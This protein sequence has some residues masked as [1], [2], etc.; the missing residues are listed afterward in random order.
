MAQQSP[1]I[2]IPKK[3][4]DE[5]DWTTPIRNL[6]AQSYG[7]SPENY[8]AEC[9]ALQRCRQDAVRGAGSEMTAR[10]LLYKYFGQLELLELRFAEIRVTFPW[11]DAFTSKLTTQT[12]LAYEKASI[13][14]QI[15][16]THSA[17]ASTQNRSDPEGLKRSFYYF[18]TAAG[19]L[20]YINENFLHAPSTDLSRDV[21]KFLVDTMIAQAHE[22]FFEKCRDEKKA[23]GLIAK[24][25]AQT[26]SL[27]SAL[28]E[29]VKEFQGK[30]I[31][32]HNWVM[33]IGIKAKYFLS[34]SHYYRSL[35]DNAAGKHGDALARLIVAE[36]AAK[37]AHTQ[38]STS[39]APYFVT[40]QSPTLPSD[41]G[42]AILDLTKT[43]LAL[44]TEKK[45][46]AQRDNDL[47]YNAV[48]PAEGTLS[49]IDKTTVA[50]PIPI[51]EV[52]GA[53]DVQKTIGPD[54][55]VKLI[56]LSVHESAS[57]YS[58]EKAKLVRG[59]VEKSDTADNEYRAA[60][61][62][63]GVREGLGRYRAM[64]EGIVAGGDVVPREVRSWQEEIRNT[65]GKE[66][67]DGLLRQL[68]RLKTN[69]RSELD[70]IG[71]D[72]EIESKDC[73][74]GRL[75]Y[76]HNWTQ[77]PSSGLTKEFRQE[78]K[79]HLSALDAASAS[80]RQ[81]TGMWESVRTDVAILLE[82]DKL[83]DVFT[84]QAQHGHERS[85]SLL[86]I[87]DEGEGDWQEREKIGG[88]VAEIEERIGRLNK[89][90]RERKETL[91]D[92][93]EKIQTDDVSHLLLLNRR[94]SS[95][96]PTLFA[97]ELEKFKPYQTRIQS[98][99][100]YQQAALQEISQYWK[101]LR[102]LAGRGAGAR[103]WEEKEKRKTSSIKQFGRARDTWMEIREGIAKGIQFYSDLLELT[104]HLRRS[105]KSFVSSRSAERQGLISK[106]E[107]ERRLT[108]SVSSPPP[109][110][111]P[112]PSMENT[113]S[114]MSLRGPSSPPPL[115]TWNRP[116][117]PPPPQQMYHSPSPPSHSPYPSQPQRSTYDQ[118]PSA[119]PH[120]P[121][122][123]G[124]LS[125]ASGISSQFSMQ[126]SN[127][128]TPSQP[129]RPPPP[130]QQSFPPLP[131]PQHQPQY[132]SSP[133]PPPP[134]ARQS[135]YPPPPSLPSQPYSNYPQSHQQ[136]SSSTSAF[137]PPPPPLPYQQYA[138]PQNNPSQHPNPASPPQ[139][140]YGQP[141][142][143]GQ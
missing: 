105:V 32:D 6:I 83:E 130:P 122:P 4:T 103:K 63:L 135:S 62:S 104:A 100:Q 26:A 120:N 87:E 13:I 71:R 55:F 110:P 134:P 140:Q 82:D 7:E 35:A 88:Y 102:D 38:A 29:G 95:V 51:Q 21:V 8:T 56:P 90:S 47:I 73:E 138:P 19:M 24:I 89:I 75:K 65:E 115:G 37:E 1:T 124:D 50:T 40:T 42:S 86:D 25:A 123:Y 16:S 98:T 117:P 34:L 33:L 119:P 28:V 94:N 126:H 91:K 129:P 57:V 52:Y 118:S 141:Y 27:Y 44:C 9:A 116:T 72:L 137:P 108:A 77:Q 10:D 84:R 3:G 67:V 2:A 69:V 111:A 106:A 5:V 18:R 15:A 41:A 30:K 46:E 39:F 133:Y 31:F 66:S 127:A 132:A 43:H 54:L 107:T 60:L 68:D 49:V 93:K 53:Q 17:I 128:P 81:A 136:R 58:E 112:P 14:F 131:P 125:K 97:S 20:T 80:D 113:F 139:A 11:R 76:E 142:R 22:V 48:L 85:G 79:G 23:S 36:K 61:D 12:S 70:S 143:Y 101:G 99:V 121:N 114:S 109:R 74:A 45:N 96:E 64:V 59:E 78:L 92:L